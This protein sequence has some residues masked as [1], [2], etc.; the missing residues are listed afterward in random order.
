[1][2]VIYMNGLVNGMITVIIIPPRPPADRFAGAATSTAP[3]VGCSPGYA[4]ITEELGRA[5]SAQW[6]SFWAS[7]LGGVSGGH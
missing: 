4:W 1:M 3:P 2:P 5:S 6:A 7:L